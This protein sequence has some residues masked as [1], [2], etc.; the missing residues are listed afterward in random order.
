MKEVQFDDL[1]EGDQ[2]IGVWSHEGNIWSETYIK[3]GDGVLPYVLYNE[4]GDLV[5]DFTDD[6]STDPNFVLT[7]LDFKAF[8]L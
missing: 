7:A 5:D 2:F 1:K 8:V 3:S 6:T 4:E